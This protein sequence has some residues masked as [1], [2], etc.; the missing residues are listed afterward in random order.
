MESL[1]QILKI[2]VINFEAILR[3][4]IASNLPPDQYT[5][6]AV[7]FLVLLNLQVVL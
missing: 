5:L 1:E 4:L 3:I 2:S 7:C 6:N